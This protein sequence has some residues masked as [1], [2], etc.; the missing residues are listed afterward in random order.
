MKKTKKLLALILSLIMVLSVAPLAMATDTET[1]PVENCLNLTLELITKASSSYL[2]PDADTLYEGFMA[3]KLAIWDVYAEVVYYSI[4][5][6][7]P[8]LNLF[9]DA[10]LETKPNLDLLYSNPELTE[11]ITDIIT[12]GINEIDL[13]I[14]KNNME[15]ILD[16]SA[17]V[18]TIYRIGFEYTVDDMRPIIEHTDEEEIYAAGEALF[19]FFEYT[20][21]IPFSSD[22]IED[23][24]ALYE[25]VFNHLIQEDFDTYTAPAI[26]YISK[27]YNCMKEIHFLTAATDNGDGTHTGVCD[28]CTLE[29]THEHNFEKGICVLCNAADEAYNEDNSD[30]NNTDSDVDDSNNSDNAEKNSLEKLF[31]SLSDLIRGNYKG[32]DLIQVI[33]DIVKLL[34]GLIEKAF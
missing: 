16:T 23:E 10:V 27:V 2:S 4:D 17:F 31:D 12:A 25:L 3:P 1:D 20:F 33:I 18:N 32:E 34:F 8:N 26:I 13:I 15:T 28:F 29:V 19:S 24:D 6:I 7:A 30:E 9:D 11:E 21:D 14:E 22:N 5:K